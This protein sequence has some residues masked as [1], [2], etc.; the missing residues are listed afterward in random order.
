MLIA[1]NYSLSCFLV[2]N[3]GYGVSTD[4]SDPNGI[5]FIYMAGAFF[6]AWGIMRW[7]AVSI[8]CGRK[9]FAQTIS[10]NFVLFAM[11]SCAANYLPMCFGI[12]DTAGVDITGAWVRGGGGL[13]CCLAMG[14]AKYGRWCADR[15]AEAGVLEDQAIYDKIMA[16][17]RRNDGEALA[18]VASMCGD[19]NALAA[20]ALL[21]PSAGR[22]TVHDPRQ[23]NPLGLSTILFSGDYLSHLFMLAQ[24]WS[25][26][27]RQ[28][29]TKLAVMSGCRLEVPSG[30][31]FD[32]IKDPKRAIEK[33]CRVYGGH[34]DRVLDLLRA[35]IVA[36]SV[37]Q[38]E[39]S[40]EL[41]I[42]GFDKRVSVRR[43]KN[44]FHARSS[45]KGGFRNIHINLVLTRQGAPPE[46]GFLCELQI[47]HREIFEAEQGNDREV[48]TPQGVRW[49]TPHQRYILYRN[50]RA[51]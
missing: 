39:T 8:A 14:R 20:K 12:V 22:G 2:Y 48:L 16:G 28:V 18:R 4:L 37:S 13:F 21:K 11:A 5:P 41:L 7:I 6:I 9:R 36:D 42:S 19:A 25:S 50:Y 43:I 27:F 32:G 23:G 17:I 10:T 33:V 31:H 47:Q 1:L 51:E 34:C 49:L 46:S 35:T 40:L 26:E 44:K 45:V 38:M 30:R 3:N 24:A 15:E 29:T